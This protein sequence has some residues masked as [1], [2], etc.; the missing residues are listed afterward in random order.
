[1][2]S[3]FYLPKF[4]IKIG[5]NFFPSFQLKFPSPIFDSS[6]PLILGFSPFREKLL[7]R[8]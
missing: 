1:M 7:L 2:F 6:F 3:G 8:V 4:G 5:H